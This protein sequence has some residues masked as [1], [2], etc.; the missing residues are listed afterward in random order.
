MKDA[1]YRYRQI[2]ETLKD[3]ILSE[4]Y[5]CDQP[6]PSVRALMRRFGVSNATAHRVISELVQCGCVSVKKGSG[7]VVTKYVRSRKIGLIVPA[8]QKAEIFS[9]V[10][11][12]ISRLSQ[13][14]DRLLFF[15][16]ESADT[17]D[18]VGRRIRKLAETLIAENVAG[19]LYHPVD[20]CPNALRIN[21]SVI[22]L[23]RKAQIPVVL[24][25]CN[26]GL[27]APSDNL[28]SVGVDN[29]EVGRQLGRHVIERGARKILYVMR[30]KWSDNVWKRLLGLRAAAEGLKGVTVEEMFVAAE[31]N[32]DFARRL[33]RKC[34][35]AIVCSSDAVAANVLQVLH[36]IG[37]RVPDDVMVTG[38][39][40]VEIAKVT[41]PTLTSVRQPCAEIA[42]AAF[43]MLEWRRSNPDALARQVFLPT[44]LI[45]RDST[46]KGWRK[47]G[48]LENMKKC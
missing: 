8:L 48:K 26:L 12:E 20:Y 21:R 15:A 31:T 9:P 34:P 16:D 33:R 10:C 36:E 17:P 38:V 35:D 3:D 44:E 43:E 32:G 40:D 30:T 46:G 22:G 4:K 7:A 39:N 1:R 47:R 5:R 41:S 11:H 23:F 29:V 28:D 27:E 6:F 45:V 37:R 2:V 13:E 19:I 24:L 25:D 18:K 42:R 14:H